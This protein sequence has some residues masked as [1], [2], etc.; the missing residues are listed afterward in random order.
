M[1]RLPIAAITTGAGLALV[2]VLYWVSYQV[3]FNETAVRIRF[4]K[5]EEVIQTPGFG[6]KLP[7]PIETVKPYD[8][9]LRVLDT[10][11]TE[12]KTQDGQILIVGLFG[13]WRIQ[14]P[15][16]YHVRVPSE[17][18]AEDKIRARLNEARNTVLGRHN[19]TELFNLDAE[20]VTAAR[21]K[22][23]TEIAAAAAPGLLADYGIKLEEVRVRRNTVPEEATQQIQAA[24]GAERAALAARYTEEG[25]STAETIRSRAR[26]AREQILQ[27]AD[28]RAKE[29]ESA[30]VRA[31]ERIFAQI[32]TDDSDFFIWLR[33]LEAIQAALKN[34]T[35]I[36][37]DSSHDLAEPMAAPYAP[38]KTSA[39][40]KKSDEKQSQ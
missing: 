36:F 30:G 14:D 19:M 33:Q 16:V 34:K 23:E 39:D 35:T 2:L 11:E 20:V 28:R 29:I 7:W 17:A 9:R 21:D 4:G 6:W 27:F 31:S 12:L 1:R 8:R 32:Q 26:A 24:M 18:E 38:G 10:P 22:I 15:M 25:K 3:R 40:K 37:L 13:L 5:A